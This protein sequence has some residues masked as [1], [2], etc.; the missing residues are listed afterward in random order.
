M[1]DESDESME[2]WLL[3]LMHLWYEELEDLDEQEVEELMDEYEPL[4]QYLL[5][6]SEGQSQPS[7]VRTPP[8]IE[9]KP[10]PVHLK[11]AFLGPDSTY[12]VIVSSNL[13]SEQLD[14]LIS[15]LQAHRKSIGWTIEDLVGVLSSYYTHRI[16]MEEGHK[17]FRD[18]KR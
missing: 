12:P 3:Q 4:P 17:V 5:E 2:H 15:V 1:E 7:K 6:V 13:S 16:Y 8:N 9:L 10:L 14:R 11:Y 18:A